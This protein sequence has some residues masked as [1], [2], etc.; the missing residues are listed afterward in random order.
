[1]TDPVHAPDTLHT[2]HGELVR[3]PSVYRPTD[4]F[5]YR[6]RNR[7][8]PPITD[9]VI[10]TCIRKGTIVNGPDIHGS[11]CFAFEAGVDHIQ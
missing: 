8:N 5:I 9:E 6:Y 1:M 3:D 2:E 7:E 11:N 4:H 10:E